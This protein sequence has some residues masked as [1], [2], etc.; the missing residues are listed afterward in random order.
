MSHY[1][2]LRNELRKAIAKVRS[3]PMGSKEFT[4]GMKKIG[5]LKEQLKQIDSLYLL[6]TNIVAWETINQLLRS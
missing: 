6:D 1:I 2:K 5:E 4:E 3:I